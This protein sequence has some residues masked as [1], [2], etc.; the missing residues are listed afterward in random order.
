VSNRD[1]EIRL[2]AF[3]RCRRL[4]DQHGGAVPWGAI[5]IGFSFEGETLVLAGK[6]RGIHRPGRMRRG[7]PSI[8]TIKPRRGRT[9]RYDDALSDDG[10]FIYAF[11]GEDPNSRD[12]VALRESFEDQTPL[13]YFYALAPGVYD[14]LFPCYLTDWDARA[15][16]CSV[17]VGSVH[18]MDGRA[19]LRLPSPSI[20]RRYTTV[21]AKVR[22]HQGEFRQ[23]VLG[24]YDSRCAI[25]GLPIPG[26]LE[27]AHIVPDRDPRGRPEISNGLCLSTLHHSAYDRSLI[28]IDPNGR[29]VVAP[30]VLEQNDGPTLEQ[31]LKGYHGKRIRLPRQDEDRPNRDALAQRFAEFLALAGG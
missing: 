29:V 20:E 13:I 18:E 25:S 7:V 21:A 5:Q 8:K 31:A 6:A 16:R 28:G 12:N 4:L 22:L 17:A 27:A 23:V 9:A 19:D 10:D 1:A 11:Q 26:L 30:G 2:A 14:I 24:A 15:L 3:A